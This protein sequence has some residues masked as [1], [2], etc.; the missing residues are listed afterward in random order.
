MLHYLR[1]GNKRVLLLWR[2]LRY[3]RTGNKRVFFFL[4]NA[5]LLVRYKNNFKQFLRK[6]HD[7]RGGRCCWTVERCNFPKQTNLLPFPPCGD[8]KTCNAFSRNSWKPL[9]NLGSNL[10]LSHNNLHIWYSMLYLVWLTLNSKILSWET[11]PAGKLTLIL[12]STF[13][14][15]LCS[16]GVTLCLS[17][18]GV[19]TI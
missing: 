15:N 12:A 6:K 10:C 7:K 14:T 16:A 5:R 18:R 17:D 1:T 8:Q 19:D 4:E 11:E 3:L 2:M 9:L 13:D